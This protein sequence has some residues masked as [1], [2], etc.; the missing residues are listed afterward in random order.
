MTRTKDDLGCE[1]QG[2]GSAQ[3][4]APADPYASAT[5]SAPPHQIEPTDCPCYEPRGTPADG[6]GL[7]P[8]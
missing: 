6:Y 4:D 8:R 3:P 2:F 5:A 7:A 1:L